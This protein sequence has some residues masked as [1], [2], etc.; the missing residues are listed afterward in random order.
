MP[1]TK[2]LWIFSQNAGGRDAFSSTRHFDLGRELVACGWD[3]TIF[4]SSFDRISRSETRLADKELFKEEVEEGVRFVWVRTPAYQKND[5][6]RVINMVAFAPR[7]LRVASGRPRP[8]VVMG[9][10]P[11]LFAA[12]AGARVARRF[13]V[14]F[15]F[16]VRDLWPQTLID[17][18]RVPPYHPA[19]RTM[20]WLE[21]SMYRQAETILVALPR[22]REY[23]ER[24][25]I[26][27]NRVRFLPNGV[28]FERFD[29]R[30][31]P[32][33]ATHERVL[34]TL[35]DRFIAA[36][37]GSHGV[38]NGL[39]ALLEGAAEL[40]RRGDDRVQI[41]LVGDGPEKPRL[42]ERARREGLHNVTFLDPL[43]KPCIPSLLARCHAGLLPLKDSPVF[44]W[45]ISPN[46][47]FDYMA[48]AL[49]VVMLC[50][51]VPENPIEKSGCGVVLGGGDGRRLGQVLASW[52]TEPG[53]ARELGRRGRHYAE[54]EHGI[55]RL[56]ARL[57]GWLNEILRPADA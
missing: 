49:P 4:A 29:R 48:A 45:G 5:W 26:P 42:V 44:R 23:I 33:P 31:E 7:V 15:V 13:A 20:A 35:A 16:E 17:V 28:D 6:R 39:D 34:D 11:P 3:V 22:A 27:G 1:K 8:D 32:L 57:D 56:A 41:L 25:G 30:A 36:Y 37:V 38:A 51:P 43:P 52:A 53:R 2:A 21:R 10:S 24:L 9:T 19:V 55:D 54:R 47:L 12:W 18:G 46:K 14:P 50:S 40:K